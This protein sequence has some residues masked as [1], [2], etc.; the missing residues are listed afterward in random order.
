MVLGDVRAILEKRIENCETC[1]IDD[2]PD[3]EKECMACAT[4]A[5][6]EGRTIGIGEETAQVLHIKSMIKIGYQ[7]A[8]DDLACWQ[9]QALAEIDQAIEKHQAEK[10]RQASRSRG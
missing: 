9:W 5:A 3:P 4:T 10:L 8:P 7:F 6:A 1:D 2:Q